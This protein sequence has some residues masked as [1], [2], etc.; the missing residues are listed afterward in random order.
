MDTGPEWVAHPPT[1]DVYNYV[2]AESDLNFKRYAEEL[3]AFGKFVHQREPYSV[4]EQI[5][6]SG[7][8][9]TIY[10]FGVF[11]LSR[12]PL[13]VTLPD[14]QGRYMSVMLVSEDHDIY[15]AKYAPVTWT[16][17][18]EDIGTRYIML[19]VRTFADPNSVEDMKKA[20]HLQDLIKV[21]QKDKGDFSGLPEWDKK[22]MLELRKAF[23]T[24]G[25]SLAKRF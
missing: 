16:I 11:D 1:V 21:E 13:T 4:E 22:K 14:S 18:Q 9:D 23:N 19:G 24:L 12:S 6:Q 17:R 10:S 8:R 3:G 5:T 7:N 2:R 15:P 20:H 25:S